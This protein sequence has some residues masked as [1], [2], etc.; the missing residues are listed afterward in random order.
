MKAIHLRTEYLK[1]PMG[2]DIERPRLFWNCEGGRKQ[3]AYQIIAKCG[4]K[5]VWDSGKVASSRM[6]HI[7][8][9]GEPLRSRQRIWW[10]VNLWDENDVGGE[11]SSAWFEMGLLEAADWKAAWITGNYKVH[12]RERYPV[13]CFRKVFSG[14]DIQSAR[15]YVT[16]CG[17][18]EGCL[19]GERIGTAVLTPGH[20]NYQNAS[21]TR[22]TM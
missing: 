3:T 13:D 15:L 9:G 11:V 19:N 10:S 2:I 7:R 18:Y 21:S 4:S 5:I 12:K 16:A 14:T 6:T 1:N 17:L 20:T 8:Y 22:P